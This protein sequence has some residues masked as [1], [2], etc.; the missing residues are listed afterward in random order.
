MSEPVLTTADADLDLVA[1]WRRGD[2]RAATELVARYGPSLARFAAALGADDRVEDV[3]QDTFIKAF[4]SLDRFR[5]E[6]S[7]G[8]WLF[9][10]ARR[11]V[12]DQRRSAR[13]LRTPEMLDDALVAPDGDALGT[14][15]AD[16]TERRLLHA[17]GRLSPMQRGVFTL[18]VVEGLSYREIAQVL[19]TSEGAARVHYHGAMR[20]VKEALDD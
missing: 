15:I 11:I 6:S 17:V 18:R 16:E 2:E 20:A 13:R 4:G 8:T 7:L 3:V 14:V 12:A 1:R 5:G 10:I 9:A 19:G